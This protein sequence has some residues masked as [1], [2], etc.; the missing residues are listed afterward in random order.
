MYPLP[1]A[2]NWI[3]PRFK[4]RHLLVGVALLVTATFTAPK[5]VHATTLDDAITSLASNVSEYLEEKGQREIMLGSFDGPGAATAGRAIR[6][7]LKEQLAAKATKV[8]PLGA[9]WTVR[10]S[11]VFQKAQSDAIVLIKA[12]LFD[13]TGKEL[14]GFR[15]K[16][17]VQEVSS[18]EDI[19]KLL[20]LTVDLNKEQDAVAEIAKSDT[21]SSARDVANQLI[22]KQTNVTDKLATSVSDPTF[23]FR[24]DTKTE[25]S[26]ST[27][28]KFRMEVLVRHEGSNQFEPIEI[29]DAGGFPFA[30]LQANDTYKIRVHND[31]DHAVG[32]KLS[33]DGI[34][35]FCLCSDQPT[36]SSGTWYIPAKSIG[37]ISGWFVSPTLLK[38]FVV[39]AK[40][41]SLGLPDAADIG[42][43]TAQFFHAWSEGEQ[44][45]AVELLAKSRGQLRTGIGRD[46]SRQARSTRSFF[47]QT[48][49]TSVSIR[50][51]NPDDLPLQ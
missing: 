47:G 3:T 16:V 33:I 6:A 42:T 23:S 51:S 44:P 7:A 2:V 22:S 29:Q 21:K 15:E 12:D 43:V 27:S 50:Y 4:T 9:S 20:G 38:E 8:V 28:S 34:N 49:L 37:V 40:G 45:P 17:K 41:E 10:G 18:I 11:F 31:A 13:K 19:S 26:P 5:S 35:S 36:K 39:T 46:I 32:V 24:S 14:S 1:Y 30:P 25:I 48:L